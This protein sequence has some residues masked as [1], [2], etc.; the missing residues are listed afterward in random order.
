MRIVE[1]V[2]GCMI[3][4][5]VVVGV[6]AGLAAQMPDATSAL[7]NRSESVVAC[8]MNAAGEPLHVVCVTYGVCCGSFWFEEA[9]CQAEYTGFG[10]A[11]SAH[12]E[13]TGADETALMSWQ[14]GVD[15]WGRTPAPAT[16]QK[17][18]AGMTMREVEQALEGENKVLYSGPSRWQRRS[19]LHRL[20]EAR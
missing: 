2:F 3:C 7:S 10:G 18:R 15:N 5:A 1:R 9:Q 16:V 13:G 8:I 11:V 4:C 20:R 14:C 17:L 19:Y 12:F 6:G